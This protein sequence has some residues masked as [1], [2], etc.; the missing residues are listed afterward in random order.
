MKE[1]I[2]KGVKGERITVVQKQNKNM[3]LCGSESHGPLEWYK[4]KDFWQAMLLYTFCLTI[5]VTV[6]SIFG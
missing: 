3:N 1:V 2:Y 6:M 4:N 5:V